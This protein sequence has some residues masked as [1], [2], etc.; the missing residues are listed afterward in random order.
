M[1]IT[2]DGSSKP[3][4]LT[5]VCGTITWRNR[6]AMAGLRKMF[7][8]AENEIIVAIEVTEDGI[9]AKFEHRT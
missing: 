6:D 8:A 7:A 4:S 1:I 9:Q 5:G 3:T 2:F